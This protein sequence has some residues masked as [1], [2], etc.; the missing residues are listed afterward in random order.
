MTRIVL[1][2]IALAW[3]PP[4]QAQLQPHP[5]PPLI[6]GW[7]IHDL[8]AADSGA[9]YFAA[10]TDGLRAIRDS[11]KHKQRLLYVSKRYPAWVE[12]I[13]DFLQETGNVRRVCRGGGTK[14][15]PDSAPWSFD[16]ETLQIVDRDT[17]RI[18][19]RIDGRRRPVVYNTGDLPAGDLMELWKSGIFVQQGSP[20]YGGSFM[21]IDDL[22]PPHIRVVRRANAWVVDSIELH[23]HWSSFPTQ[24]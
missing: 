16:L 8:P 11:A 9:I 2:S 10:L 21:L 5:D 24:H 17:A 12:G 4:L 3:V 1:L 7:A 19:F 15:C 6:P 23:E 13:L 18:D 22:D 14:D 20:V